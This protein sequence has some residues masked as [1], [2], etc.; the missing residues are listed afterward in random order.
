MHFHAVAS[1]AEY[2]LCGLPIEEAMPPFPDD[3]T[4]LICTFG[5]TQQVLVVP[6]IW[7]SCTRRHVIGPHSFHV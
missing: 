6:C 7:S 2:V 4:G 5:G 1:N 3:D